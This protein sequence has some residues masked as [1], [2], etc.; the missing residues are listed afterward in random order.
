[1]ENSDEISE[2]E[3]W[4]GIWRD[5]KVPL[6]VVIIAGICLIIGTLLVLFWIIQVNLFVPPSATIGEWTMNKVV[7]FLIQ[8]CLAELLFVGAPAGLFFGLGGYIWW[9]SLTPEKK[10]FFKDREKKETHRKRDYGG[11][12]GFGFFMFIFY[13]IYL[14]FDRHLNVQFGSE[15]YTYW[16]YAWFLTIMWLL[17]YIGIPAA[18]ILLI[19]YFAYW[20]KKRTP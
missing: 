15:P 2:K 8:L 14:G 4:K 6:V 16:V 12:G 11:G 17:I 20:R 18:I 3:F 10:Q 1:M 9:R 5:Y 19:V 13:L 7:G